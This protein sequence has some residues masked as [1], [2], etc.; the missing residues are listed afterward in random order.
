[1]QMQLA[2]HPDARH[3]L[4]ALWRVQ[5]LLDGS[6]HV[7]HQ[8]SAPPCS[9]GVPVRVPRAEGVQAG[10]QRGRRGAL[11]CHPRQCVVNLLV[12]QRQPHLLHVCTT[13]QSR[14]S[15]CAAHLLA[16]SCCCSGAHGSAASPLL[17]ALCT[18]ACTVTPCS[19]A[20]KTL[21]KPLISHCLAFCSPRGR[22]L[23]RLPPQRLQPDRGRHQRQHHDELR[24]RP[25]RL[26]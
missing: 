3:H 7:V 21:T 20:S 26:R 24:Q 22:T 6:G 15:A 10:G 9:A 1:M 17:C 23:G 5:P 13:A 19:A 11:L 8:C 18:R 25:Q 4:G 2:L 16:H 12:A 14:A